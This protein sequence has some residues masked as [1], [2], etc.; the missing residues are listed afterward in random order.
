MPLFFTDP[1]YTRPE[2]HPEHRPEYHRGFRPEYQPH[3]RPDDLPTYHPVSGSAGSGF[4]GSS[5]SSGSAGFGSSGASSFSTSGSSY[6]SYRPVSSGGSNRRENSNT[7]R[8]SRCL[9]SEGESFRQVRHAIKA[10]ERSRLL[11]FSFCFKGPVKDKDPPPVCPKEG[12]C[13][14]AS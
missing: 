1:Y 4:S 14:L 8:Q 6:D 5:G 10:L 12:D 11:V 13:Q 2:T 3:N 9:D 7:N